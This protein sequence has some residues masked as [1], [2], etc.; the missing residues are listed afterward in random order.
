MDFILALCCSPVTSW[1]LAEQQS[2]NLTP[3][4]LISSWYVTMRENLS[5]AGPVDWLSKNSSQDDALLPECLTTGTE[6]PYLPRKLPP[7]TAE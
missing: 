2:C 4:I 1:V 5:T 7:K 3:A 6:I